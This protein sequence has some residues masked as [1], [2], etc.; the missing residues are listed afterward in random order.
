MPVICLTTNIRA[1]IDQCFDLARSIEIHL[2]ST[3]Q[4][5]EK[6]VGRVTRGLIGLNDEVTWEAT[7]F[8]IRQRLTSRITIW[9]RPNHFRDSLVHGAFKSFDHDHFFEHDHGVTTMNDRFEY[10]SPL[11][12]LGRLADV[13]FLKRYMERLLRTRAEVIRLAAE[14]SEIP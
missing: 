3:A 11:G 6:A 10:R 8:C 4:T 13:L 7:H 9:D 14:A 2:R 5:H 12:P 1:P